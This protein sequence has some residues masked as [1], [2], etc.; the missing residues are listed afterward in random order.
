LN[1]LPDQFQIK[2]DGLSA[3][4]IFHRYFLDLVPQFHTLDMFSRIG[5]RLVIHFGPRRKLQDPRHLLPETGN[6][7]V[8][9]LD[10]EPRA[11]ISK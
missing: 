1:A 9:S 7:S 2:L 5:H 11:N 10:A 3:K 8:D 6:C 4:Q